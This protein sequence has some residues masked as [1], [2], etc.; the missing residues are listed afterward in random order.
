MSSKL[1]VQGI[2]RGAYRE[3]CPDGVFLK[4][5]MTLLVRCGRWDCPVCGPRKAKKLMRRA[6]NGQIAVEG[7]ENGFRDQYNFKLLTL[8]YGGSEKRRGATPKEAAKEMSKAFDKLIK[9]MRQEFGHF[10]YL[11]VFEAHKEGGW[12]HL[13][14]LL[15]GKNIAPTEV[16][17]YIEKLWRY[18]YHFGFIKLNSKPDTRTKAIS[19]TLKYLFKDPHVFEG[20]HLFSSSRNA[21]E[22]ALQKIKRLW[23]QAELISAHNWKDASKFYDLLQEL[24][25][26]ECTVGIEFMPVAGCPF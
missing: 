13:H 22:Q 5:T 24:A 18:K 4:K 12:P 21:L 17:T 16:R 8:T 10:L 3:Q 25:G 23:E 1:C 15:V 2:F 14:V 19:Y 20:V 9:A 11:K 7:V 26:E 6:L